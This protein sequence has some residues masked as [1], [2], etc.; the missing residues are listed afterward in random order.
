MRLYRHAARVLP[1]TAIAG[2]NTFVLYFALPCMLF[3]FGAQ[4][5]IA[6]LSTRWSASIYLGCGLLLV[7]G[8]VAG[9]RRR[10]GWNDAAFGA[11]VAAFP[12]S[13]FMG[14][15][16][17]VALLGP[18]SAGHGDPDHGH[19]H[20]DHHLAVHCLS[21]LGQGKAG[22][23]GTAHGPGRRADQPP[24]LGDCAGGPGLG[25]AAAA[26]RAYRSNRGHAAGAA[27]LWPCL[28]L[29]PCWP[30]RRLNQAEHVAPR[31]YV[32]LA[33]AK[34]LLHPVLVWAACQAGARAWAHA[35]PR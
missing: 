19:G 4:T 34:L 11:L 7:A 25:H 26:A 9:H 2:L 35:W 15:P 17:L 30:A 10:W 18:A 32:P 23:A 31:H 22:R 24:A 1:L 12:N 6:Q 13:G 20:G 21:R 14:V 33:L 8:A 16:L 3:R 5:P 27:R 29:V 28:P